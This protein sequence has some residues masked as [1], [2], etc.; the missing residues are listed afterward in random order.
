MGVFKFGK[1]KAAPAATD[2]EKLKVAEEVEPLEVIVSKAKRELDDLTAPPW[3]TTPEAMLDH[4]A[5][6]CHQRD[7]LDADPMR[8]SRNAIAVR[9]RQGYLSRSLGMDDSF[10]V[11]IA[12][13]LNTKVW[14]WSDL[15]PSSVEY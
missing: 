5:R 3:A 1:S 4:I 8:T 10:I 9:A 12:A 2:E 6:V 11:G 14:L 7:W 15:P 13:H